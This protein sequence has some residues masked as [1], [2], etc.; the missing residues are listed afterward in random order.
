MELDFDRKAAELVA[1]GYRFD[2]RVYRFV[3]EAVTYTVARC[4]THRH[5]SAQELLAGVRQMAVE[6][7]GKMACRVMEK[8]GL[9]LD[10]DV[11]EVVY[12]LIGVGLLGESEEDSPDD[13]KS[14]NDLFP[15]L[16]SP[17]RGHR[18]PGKLPFI[19]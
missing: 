13:F 15:E 4:D 1:R 17:R 16:P 6:R 2:A 9:K 10:D 19:D 7:F 3:A 5:V 12:L 14:G 8:W 11:G 18:K